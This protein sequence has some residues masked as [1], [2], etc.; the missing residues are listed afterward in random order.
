MRPDLVGHIGMIPPSH[1]LSNGTLVMEK[2]GIQSACEMRNFHV[3]LQSKHF[4]IKR[5]QI[6][7]SFV[8]LTFMRR[9]SEGRT[10]IGG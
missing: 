4:F 3:T 8:R 10:L 6:D 9:E 1:A 5:I 7:K 2:Q